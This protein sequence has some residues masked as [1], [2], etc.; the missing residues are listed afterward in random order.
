M[1]K[2]GESRYFGLLKSG[3][4]Y[5]EWVIISEPYLGSGVNRRGGKKKIECRVRCRCSCGFEN[6][7]T[8]HSLISGASK[9]CWKCGYSN[10][11][12]KNPSWKGYKEIPQTWFSKYF[13]RNGVRKKHSGTITLQFIHELWLK[14]GKKCALSG[15]PIDWIKTK[16]GISCSIDRIDSKLEYTPEN[17]QLVHKDVNL[18]KNYFTQEYFVDMCSNIY[19]F[20]NG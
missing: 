16:N 13:L 2:K 1:G 10:G 18:M 14:Q 6:D 7:I 8:A 4:V 3:D 19:K 11:M 17:I 12:E 9:R 15:V 20:H 5:N